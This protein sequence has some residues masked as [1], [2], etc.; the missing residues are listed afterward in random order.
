MVDDPLS[1]AQNDEGQLSNP[2]FSNVLSVHRVLVL[3][4]TKALQMSRLRRGVLWP[5]PCS[6]DV[7]PPPNW[8]HE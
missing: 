3:P 7:S 1:S 8:R 2:D 5:T 4:R 6:L